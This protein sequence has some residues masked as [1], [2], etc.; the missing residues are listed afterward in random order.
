MNSERSS[1][2]AVV[3]SVYNP[4]I[5]DL[6]RSLDGLRSQDVPFHLVLVDDGSPDV[7]DYEKLMS[8]LSH[9]LI[10]L[11]KNRGIPGA[12]N[13]GLDAI[14]DK[15]FKYIARLDCD[16]VMLPDRLRIQRAFL[17]ANPDV[18]LVGSDYDLVYTNF[19][20]KFIFRNPND[21]KAI[22]DRLF[23]NPSVPQPTWMF[24]ADVLW[25]LGPYS[26]EYMAA[27][28]Y[29]FI[30]RVGWR[31]YKIA[32]IPEVLLLKI[33][34]GNSI[35][36]RKYRTQRVSR[37]RIQWRYRDFSNP[38]FYLGIS[39]TL[40]QLFIPRTMWHHMKQFVR[41]V[42]S[43]TKAPQAHSQT[44]NAAGTAIKKAA[45]DNKTGA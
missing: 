22:R 42:R 39:R 44:S 5:G 7:P 40:L 26:E 19:G 8:G 30:R 6:V 4:E 23:Y 29:E 31:G 3:M 34:S 12:V 28:D 18:A 14:R 25:E 24:R 11:P 32:N 33:E 2:I 10:K 17:A 9:T 1:D 36:Q 43:Q 13:I 20:T 45:A 38:H 15:H 37:L 21:D 27:E 35:S 16:D 41:I